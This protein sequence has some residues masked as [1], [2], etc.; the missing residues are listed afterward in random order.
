[1]NM[2][3]SH[4]NYWNNSPGLVLRRNE[5]SGNLDPLKTRISDENISQG[6]LLPA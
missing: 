2:L 6:E 1:M 5:S 4:R 3:Q